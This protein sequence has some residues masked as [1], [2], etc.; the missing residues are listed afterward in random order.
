M[1]LGDK[2]GA[3]VLLYSYAMFLGAAYLFA[4]WRPIGLNIFPY[5]QPLDYIAVPLNRLA[6]LA[7]PILIALSMKIDFAKQTIS[8]WEK[9]TL[10]GLVLG[11]SV[12]FILEFI[13][14]VT[15]FMSIDNGFRNE[16]TVLMVCLAM[17]LMAIA[18]TVL[19][20]RKSIPI[21]FQTM[22]LIMLQIAE[23]MSAG[24]GDGKAIYNGGENVLFE[25]SGVCNNALPGSWVYLD[26]FGSE[27][28]FLNT[29]SKTICVRDKPDF[30]LIPRK[31]VEVL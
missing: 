26:R 1:K 25:T 28:L 8:P 3:S 23:V 14:S 6:V 13:K 29:Y 2:I 10:A 9:W 21:F 27:V 17:F 7:A 12:G 16:K 30:D 11:Y 18:L 15:L 4:F 20:L 19:S 22:A 31:R 5:L 24:Y